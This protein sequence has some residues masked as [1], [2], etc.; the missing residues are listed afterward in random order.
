MEPIP[1]PEFEDI[2]DGPL[3]VLIGK[4][5][6]PDHPKGSFLPRRELFRLEEILE[7]DESESDFSTSIFARSYK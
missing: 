4:P 3:P 1:T 5:L 6:E 7:P 2:F